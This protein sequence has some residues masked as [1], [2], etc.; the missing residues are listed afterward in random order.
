MNPASPAAENVRTGFCRDCLAAVPPDVMRCPHCRAPRLLRHPELFRLSIAH[1]DCDAFYAAVEKR[2]D[3]ALRD[4][5]LIIGG[6]RRG[7][8]STACYIARIRGVASA[9]PMFK[10]LKLCPDA[11]VLHPDM[12]KYARVGRE[13]RAL[14]Q[15]L[16]PLVEPLSIDEAFLDLTG[17]ERLHHLQPA[18][19]LARLAKRIE[20]E[21]GI[22]V[23]IGLSHNKFLAKI[24][25]D[26]DKPRG[27][28]VIGEA[29]TATFLAAQPVSLIWGV[30]KAMQASLAKSGI[31]MIRQLQAMERRDLVK[32]YGIMGDRL[33]FLSRGEDHRRVNPHEEMKSISAETTFNDDIADGGRLET[34]LWELSEKVSRRAKG[35]GLAGHTVTLKLKTADF[36]LRTRNAT[37]SDPTLLAER[38]FAAARPLLLREATGTAFR[39]IGVGVSHLVPSAADETLTGLDPRARALARAELAMDKVRERFGSAAVGKGRGLEG[40]ERDP[41]G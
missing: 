4:K 6:G 37:L 25:S 29:E 33:Y 14:M 2:D 9:M 21:L 26:L 24:A 1:I 11:V 30:G 27:F 38:I 40:K 18:R 36:R 19:S 3:P 10:A 35:Y 22:T 13:V 8:V 41:A 39:L 32:R 23:S 34:I 5:P 20:S 7:V 15:E 17:T 12:A 28:S 31:T 16:T